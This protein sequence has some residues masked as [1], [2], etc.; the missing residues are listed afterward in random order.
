[1]SQKDV[2]AQ[3]NRIAR[4]RILLLDGG[5][6]TM[7]QR[8]QLSEDDFRGARYRNH[9]KSLK[10]NNDILVLS[11]PD[12]VSEIHEAYLRAGSDIIETNAFNAQALSQSEY[13]LEGDIYEMNVVAA[14]LARAAADKFS[15][16]TPDQPRFVAGNLGPTSRTLSMSVRVDDPSHREADFDQVCDAYRTQATGLIEGGVDII[17]IETIF[18]TLNAKAAVFALEQ[19]FEE[20]GIRLPIMMSVTVADRSGRTLAG[21]TA[22][23]FFTSIAHA[24]PFSVGLNCALGAA[25]MRPYLESLARLCPTLISCYPN[26]GLPNAFGGYDETPETMADVLSTFAREGLVNIVGGCCGTSD[27]H[28]RA[29]GDAVRRCEPRTPPAPDGLTRYSGLETLTL[30]SDSNFTMIGE[31]TNVTGSKRFAR[32]IQ[33]EDF[34]TALQ[35]ASEQIQNG[36]NIIDV[37]MDEAM[38]DSEAMMAKFLRLIATEPDIA[39]VPVMIDSSKW[40]V[41]VAGLK[42][43]QGKSIVNSISLKEGEAEFLQRARIC[44]S[45]G[46]AVVVMAFDEQGQAE[47]ADRKFQICE[48]AYRLLVDRVGFAPEDIIFDPNVF[49]VATGIEGHNRFGMEF[50]EATKRIKQHLPGAKV[51]GGIS[52]LSFSFRGNDRV[53]EAFHSA[54]LYHAIRD[55]LDMGIVNA[56]QLAV[57]ED[58]PKDLLE[59]VEDVLFDRRPD[60]TERMVEIADNYKGDAAKR[61]VDL[62][63]RDQ[64][65]AAR[66]RYALVHGIVDYIADDCEE[67]RLSL[68]S[69][70]AVIEGPMMDGMREVGDLFGAGKMFLPQVVKSARVMKKG[71]AMLEPH[72][73][74][75]KQ[76]SGAQAATKILLATVKGDVHDIGKNIVGVVLGCNNYDV[77]D[78]GVMVPAE[79]ILDR[80]QQEGVDMIGLSGLITPS[81][82]EMVHVAKEMQRRGFRVP[83]L[84]GGAT[85]SRQHTAVKIAPEYEAEVV[86]VLDASRA[87]S[88]VSGLLDRE[89]RKQFDKNNRAEQE[90]L[91]RLHGGTKE[92]SLISLDAARARRFVSDSVPTPKPPFFGRRALDIDLAELVNYIDWT[93][94]FTA[95]DMVGKYPAILSHPERGEAAREL[96]DSG[97]ALL[98]RIVKERLLSARAVYGYWPACAQC[99]DIVLYRQEAGGDAVAFPMLRQQSI[100]KPDDPARCLAD[101]VQPANGGCRDSVGA[102][103][104]T[105]GLGAQALVERFERERDDY[106]AILV[107]SLADRLAEAAAEWLHQRVRREW[108]AAG[109]SLS[110]Q[111]L[112]E[113]KYQGI[114]PAL[115]YPACPDHTLKGRLFE[116]LQAQEIGMSLTE[117][118]AMMPAA[119]VSGIY[120]AH[121]EAR[122]FNVGKIGRDQVEDYA[123]RQG[124]ELGTA[125]K[126]LSPNLGYRR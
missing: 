102:F 115:G 19:L 55:G 97:R 42:N 121:P 61:T 81:L 64:T 12:I 114:R 16:L 57:Y 28:I 68:N 124:W 92:A 85:T 36:A 8:Y 83:L 51:S 72:I 65:V 75:A 31:R 6:G 100:K 49:A 101:F 84:I 106:S 69:P 23:A 26:A 24:R 58:V 103:A 112:V 2:S 50:I 63:W 77:I 104:V 33:S 76:A 1:M 25:D 45:Y 22:D 78:L 15:D 27:A 107:K 56:G 91:R 86:H 98:D 99:D 41:I 70:L 52:N 80:A 82:E 62:S 3:L 29:I 13:G 30:R 94:F 113:E 87:V 32:L 20:K 111:Q 117:N 35:V 66:I 37:N 43:V 46:A 88:V 60:A 122:Y 71:V 59:R 17:L 74:A 14:R 18:D 79:T 7:V 11:R 120:L 108:Y 39:K 73:L 21:Q 118:F 34:A 5:M 48:R 38:L 93:F 126:W 119:S 110:P 53:R 67:A 44:H 47:G 90:Q 109:E 89:A 4:D 105:A 95:W 54:F 96:F 10:G 116:L 123:K 125:E 9:P 40:S